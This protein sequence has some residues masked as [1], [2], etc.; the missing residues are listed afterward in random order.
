MRCA[1]CTKHLGE[2]GSNDELRTYRV[3]LLDTGK[4]FFCDPSCYMQH[5]TQAKIKVQL[6][7]ARVALW[8]RRR[9]DLA[10]E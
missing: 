5:R 8:K 7:Q 10:L 3:S 1:F 9:D 4:R 2:E 6:N